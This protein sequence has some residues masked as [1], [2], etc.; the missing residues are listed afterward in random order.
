MG[1]L[2]LL[3]L[4]LLLLMLV[5]VLV[6][7]VVRLSRRGIVSLL[8]MRWVSLWLPPRVRLLLLLLL[9]LWRLRRLRRLLLLPA[10]SSLAAAR[11]LGLRLVARCPW[12]FVVREGVRCHP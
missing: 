8:V 10:P 5:L 2:L 11:T 12:G 3:L 1:V 9:L 7:V 6:V 4:L